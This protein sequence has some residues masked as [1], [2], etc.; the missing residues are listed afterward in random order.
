MSRAESGY[1]WTDGNEVQFHFIIDGVA[2]IVECDINYSD[3][4]N[5]I[6]PVDIYVNDALIESQTCTESGKLKFSFPY[7][8]GGIAD[9][10]L[11]LPNAC[12]PVYVRISDDSR[13]LALQIQNIIFTE[14]QV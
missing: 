13:D 12:S 8:E 7:P 14:Y 2:D 11:V 1:S 4:F 5:G 3:T 10:K 9:I 6:Q